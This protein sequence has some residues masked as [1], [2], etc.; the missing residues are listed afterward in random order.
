MGEARKVSLVEGFLEV[1]ARGCVVEGRVV[2]VRGVCPRGNGRAVVGRQG[3]KSQGPVG[4][5]CQGG[6]VAVRQAVVLHHPGHRGRA[7]QCHE[8]VGG[9]RG[10]D[11]HCRE[12]EG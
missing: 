8:A 9:H 1:S 6:C 3:Y 4:G 10:R 12:G 11:R 2:V 5:L 7:R